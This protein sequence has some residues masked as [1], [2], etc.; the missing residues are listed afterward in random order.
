MFTLK[1]DLARFKTDS[2]RSSRIRLVLE[3]NN[4]EQESGDEGSGQEEV[5]DVTVRDNRK[6][7]KAKRASRSEGLGLSVIPPLGYC[8][9]CAE[10][11]PGVP[12][13]SP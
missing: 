2:D 7:R 5:E 13:E 11:R 4:Q 6:V 10:R 8:S 12:R 9:S 3:V 1:R